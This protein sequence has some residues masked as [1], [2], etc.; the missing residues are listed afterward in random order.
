[1]LHPNRRLTE[2]ALA[3]AMFCFVSPAVAEVYVLGNTETGHVVIRGNTEDAGMLAN[4][5]AK[6]IRDT[7]WVMLYGDDAL[8]WGAVSCVKTDKGVQFSLSSG[9]PSE[10]EAAR[11]AKAGADKVQ[12]ETG[13]SLM[14]MCAPRWN[15]RGQPLAFGSDGVPDDRPKTDV[16][17]N[18]IDKIQGD[19]LEKNRS[20]APKKDYQRDCVPPPDAGRAELAP[21]GS[22]AMQPKDKRPPAKMWKPAEW[23][24]PRENRSSGIRG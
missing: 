23:C 6:G 8:G 14:F 7:G 1:M 10:L 21:I 18:A 17:D 2:A 16:V 4:R 20:T 3:I 5:E 15:N 22:G 13:G 9:H 12:K 19:I 11:L 24:P